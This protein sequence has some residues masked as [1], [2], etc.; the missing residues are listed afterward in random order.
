LVLMAMLPAVVDSDV[1]TFGR[2]L[3]EVQRINGGW[4]KAAQGGTFAPGAT[5][6]LIHRM[7]EWGAAGVGQSSWGPTV[8]GVVEGDAAARDLTARVRGALGGAGSVCAGPFP[9]IG[10]VMSRGDIRNR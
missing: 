2:A 10:A 8:Y 5:T 7:Q 6:D 1:S 3:S 4:F 9:S